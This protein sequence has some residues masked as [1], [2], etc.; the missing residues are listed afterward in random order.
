M[1]FKGETLTKRE[2]KEEK[3]FKTENNDVIIL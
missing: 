2:E 3:K 1:L